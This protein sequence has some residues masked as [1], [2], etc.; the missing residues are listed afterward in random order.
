MATNFIEAE[1][2]KLE[3]R[4]KKIRENPDPTKLK[5]NRLLYE[6][7]L[8]RRKKFLEDWRLNKPFA[9]TMGGENILEAMGINC[10]NLS[11]TA[12]RAA[13]YAKEY[14][15]IARSVGFPDNVCDRFQVAMGMVA[16]DAIPKPAFVTGGS[17]SCNIEMEMMVAAA[18]MP[19]YGGGMKITPGASPESGMFDVCI[20][21]R[22]SKLHFVKVFPKVFEGKHVDDPNVEIFRT[23]ELTLDSEYHFSVFADGEYICKLPATFK[24]APGKIDF[25]VP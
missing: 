4:V 6:M 18:N 3:R 9:Y 5:S 24:M 7:E 13:A 14:L 10:L 23:N 22:M 19:S 21:K 25:L 20:I 8:K 11:M 12:D 16:G 17:S 2:K 1:V 15:D